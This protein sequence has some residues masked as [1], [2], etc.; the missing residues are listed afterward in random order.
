MAANISLTFCHVLKVPYFYYFYCKIKKLIPLES[1]DWVNQKRVIT[2][3]TYMYFNLCNSHSF[4]RIRS[5]GIK[6]KELVFDL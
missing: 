6:E 5:L 1:K 4:R 2:K 3:R